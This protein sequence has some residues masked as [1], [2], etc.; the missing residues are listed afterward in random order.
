V[1]ARVQRFYAPVK[2]FRKARDLGYF[3]YVQPRRRQ[4]CFGRTGGNDSETAFDEFRGEFGY[5]RF[6][7]YA[8]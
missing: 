8:Y 2:T 7:V 1:D 4:R 3:G 6:I 5:P